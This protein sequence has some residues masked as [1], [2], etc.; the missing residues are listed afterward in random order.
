MEGY[1][2]LEYQKSETNQNLP[3]TFSTA[4][5]WH[6]LIVLSEGVPEFVS[7]LSSSLVTSCLPSHLV[8]PPGGYRT[9][10][11]SQIY[12]VG[13]QQVVAFV[14]SLMHLHVAIAL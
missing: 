6:V 4:S 10:A 5:M 9:R 1:Q 11:E 13:A 7:R 3:K 2:I 14:S 8:M 12:R